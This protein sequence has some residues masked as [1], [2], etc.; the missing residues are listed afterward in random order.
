MRGTFNAMETRIKRMVWW[1]KPLVGMTILGTLIYWVIKDGILF[2]RISLSV[3]A[4]ATFA[5]AI[6]NLLNALIV[7]I[8]VTVYGRKI[9][10]VKS[11]YLSVLGTF[12]NS[13]GGLPLGTTL[14]YVLLHQQSGLKIREITAGLVIFTFA[15]SIFLLCYT[16]VSV[17]STGLPV[18]AKTTPTLILI[19][20]T[21]LLPLAWPHFRKRRSIVTL[22]EPFLRKRNLQLL[23]ATSA[24][25]A[26]G[27][28]CSYWLVATLLLPEIPTLTILFV[29]SAG[30]LTSLATLLQSVGGIQELS[31]G[32]SAHL[33][34]IRVIDGLQ[35]ALVLRVA[36]LLSS[37][38]FLALSYAG[39]L[40]ADANEV[41]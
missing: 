13:A 28:V 23:V 7:K 1:L 18:A 20:L 26:T 17:W 36:S 34:G 16:A 19:M 38:L 37:G 9:S 21:M 39:L 27:F 14:K 40:R 10:F 12:G 29:A 5:S 8:I 4:I 31:V 41:S 3:A 32:L 33:S 25:T 6:L 11:L 30:T 24:M 35:V 2:E 22:V 15:T